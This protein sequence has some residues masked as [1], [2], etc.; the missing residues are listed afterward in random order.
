M[1]YKFRRREAHEERLESLISSFYPQG[2]FDEDDDP[3]AP[4]HLAMVYIATQAVIDPPYS[5]S[6]S[7][8]KVRT[9]VFE[10]YGWDEPEGLGWDDEVRHLV[11][12][13]EN[14]PASELMRL[15]FYAMLRPVEHDSVVFGA[16][17]GGEDD[18]DEQA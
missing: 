1:T 12:L 11:G 2:L 4:D 7:K 17:Y 9:A 10:R 8:A 14:L 5:S 13:L 18:N 16:V 6:M 15:V 3:D